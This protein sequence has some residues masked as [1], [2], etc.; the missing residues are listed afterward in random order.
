MQMDTAQTM[1]AIIAPLE[2]SIDPEELPA[3]PAFESPAL[4][5]D[6]EPTSPG[7]GPD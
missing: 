1:M 3:A 4:L 2:S 5:P 6:E 7:A